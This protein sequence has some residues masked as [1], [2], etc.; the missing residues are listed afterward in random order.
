MALL[1]LTFTKSTTLETFASAVEE[2]RAGAVWTKSVQPAPLQPATT[3]DSTK[4]AGPSQLAPPGQA[5]PS[6][7]KA[8]NAG[9]GGH[10]RRAQEQMSRNDAML[11]NAF[12]NLE[13]CA[14]LE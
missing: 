3:T 8:S 10:L 9:V 13:V 4:N 7:F 1:K 11:S 2:A 12:S 6:V 14:C 5:Q